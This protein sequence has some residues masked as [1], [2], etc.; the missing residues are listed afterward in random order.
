MIASMDLAGEVGGTSGMGRLL[1][2]GQV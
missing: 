1:G 2:R